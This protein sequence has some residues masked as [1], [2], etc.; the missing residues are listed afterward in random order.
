MS[1]DWLARVGIGDGSTVAVVNG[2]NLLVPAWAGEA[3]KGFQARTLTR[4]A[5]AYLSS[6]KESN[7]EAQFARFEIKTKMLVADA[8]V[9]WSK[10]IAAEK[11]TRK[12]VTGLMDAVVGTTAVVARAKEDISAR[13]RELRRLFPS[14]PREPPE[15]PHLGRAAQLAEQSAQAAVEAVVRE[16]ARVRAVELGRAPPQGSALE[17]LDF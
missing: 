1:A 10:E 4:Y 9:A 12:L 2:R 6:V 15:Q 8:G 14:T 5:S 3:L 17:E 13:A 16:L 11:D 7:L